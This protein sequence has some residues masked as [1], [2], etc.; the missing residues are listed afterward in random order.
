MTILNIT[1]LAIATDV[2]EFIHDYLIYLDKWISTENAQCR[3]FRIS[4]YL[5]PTH[6]RPWTFKNQ[7]IM[8]VLRSSEFILH[9]ITSFPQNTSQQPP[10][11]YYDQQSLLYVYLYMIYHALYYHHSVFDVWPCHC[12]QGDALFGY[13]D[14][15]YAA[16]FHRHKT[17]FV[18]HPLKK[19][20]QCPKFNMELTK[21]K[22]TD[23]R[24]TF[25]I[26]KNRCIPLKSVYTCNFCWEFRC[27]SPLL[28]NVNELKVTNERAF[29]LNCWK[30]IRE[31][32]TG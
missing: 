18:L 25:H 20:P 31:A 21:S 26:G 8:P 10:S 19:F 29:S 24:L 32:P 2:V 30:R 5:I 7:I 12:Y 16:Y 28:I 1:N 23:V 14:D 22:K 13:H 27:D 17:L 11:F 9:M 4:E 3:S 6:S 15:G